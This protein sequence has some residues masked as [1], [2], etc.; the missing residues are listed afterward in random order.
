VRRPLALAIVLGVTFASAHAQA[1]DVRA[2]LAAADKGQHA[3]AAGKL[4]EARE[5][6][7][8]CGG[9]GCPTL[10]RRDCSQ[11]Q[12][13]IA[14]AMPSVVFGAKDK[15]GRDLFDVTVS[16]DGEPLVKKLD[17][18]SVAVDPGPHTFT[19]ELAGQPAVV[20]RALVK[21]GE[22]TRPITVT[23][24]VESS[25]PAVVTATRAPLVDRPPGEDPK[26]AADREHTIVPWIVV[27]AGVATVIAGTIIVIAAPKLPTNCSDATKTCAR[28][29]TESAEDFANDQADAGN[30]ES[31]PRL[32]IIVG[33]VG[34]A[35]IAGGLIWHFLEPTGPSKSGMVVSPWAGPGAAGGSIG[36]RF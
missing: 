8:I 32:G 34:L 12:T 23:F 19:F 28:L 10:V 21:E 13:E 3:R 2:C 31:Q 4:R 11:W 17:G 30:S 33:G 16:M 36:G 14:S 27:G 22:K 6:L 5:Q 7:T 25:G 29:T 35:M 1:T 15:Q 9:E 18:K 20:E 24:G 26:S